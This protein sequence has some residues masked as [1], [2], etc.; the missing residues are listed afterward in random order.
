MKIT[1]DYWNI[2]NN[3]G[4]K[5][6]LKYRHVLV[7][8]G[9]DFGIYA[10]DSDYD[11]VKVDK[12]KQ[13]I[14]KAIRDNLIDNEFGCFYIFYDEFQLIQ[15]SDIPEIIRTADCKLTLY[16]NC[17]N[18]QNIATASIK[19]VN[20]NLPVTKNKRKLKLMEG[21]LPGDMSR[22][23]YCQKNNPN[24]ENYIIKDIDD[25]I[26]F[27]KSKGIQPNE[28][29]VLTCKTMNT[30]ILNRLNTINNNYYYSKKHK[31]IKISTCRKFKGLE[32]LVVILV[33]VTKENYTN[34]IDT[35]IYYVGASRAKLNLEII[36]LFSEK[37]CENILSETFGMSLPI[38]N[39]KKQ[40]AVT[41]GCIQY[42]K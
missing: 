31:D 42:H 12:I 7:D 30:S 36:T 27:Y 8:E 40:L 28:I 13:E 6:A 21:A 14:L 3:Y 25:C 33:D 22:I 35:K 32:S 38:N 2:Y 39:P 26:S 29:I 1:K 24:D 10:E 34:D 16:K 18:T 11:D 5:E 19:S 37:D 9:Q 41:L 17:R 23:H 20:N 4:D 15:S